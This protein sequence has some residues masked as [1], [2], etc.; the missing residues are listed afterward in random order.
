M[1]VLHHA[2]IYTL[3]K[4]KPV[5][6]AIAIDHGMIVAVGGD[7]LLAEFDRTEKQNMEGRVILPGLTDAHLHL[8]HYVLSLEKIDCETDTLEECLRRVAERARKA[9]PGEWI[10]GHGW[11]QNVWATPS[12]SPQIL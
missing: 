12:I 3:D 11:N 8:Q 2:Q 7:E 5:A 4:S 6:S 1:K 9:N 10:L